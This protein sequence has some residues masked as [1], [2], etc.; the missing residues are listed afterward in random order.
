VNPGDEMS[1]EIA[2][3]RLASFTFT[4]AEAA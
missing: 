4:V 3:E 2:V 1:W